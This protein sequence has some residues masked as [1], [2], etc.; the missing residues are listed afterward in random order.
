MMRYRLR[1]LLIAM[2]VVAILSALAGTTY[3]RSRAAI[4]AAMR[5]RDAAIRAHEEARASIANPTD[6]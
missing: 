4:E 1:S 2:L 3:R 5:A 6:N